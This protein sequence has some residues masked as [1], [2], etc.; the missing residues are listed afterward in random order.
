[1]K[2]IF[3]LPP[4]WALTVEQ[5]RKSGHPQGRTPRTKPDLR[6]EI[7]PLAQG[8][9][10]ASP[11]RKLVHAPKRQPAQ[12]STRRFRL[13][14]VNR[15]ADRRVSNHNIIL[16]TAVLASLSVHQH[17]VTLVTKVRTKKSRRG[18]LM[19]KSSE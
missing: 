6:I 16:T 9:S 17:S 13:I 8:S 14:R 15:S 4:Q 3:Q 18:P 7:D 1:M 12:I 11:T 10:L 19:A 2:S 5:T